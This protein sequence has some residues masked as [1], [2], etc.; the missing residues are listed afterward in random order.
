ML[1]FKHPALPKGIKLRKIPDSRAGSK[2][3]RRMKLE[4]LVAPES[5]KVF[6]NNDMPKGH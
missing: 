4:H 3:R 5:K 1:A 2:R 6:K